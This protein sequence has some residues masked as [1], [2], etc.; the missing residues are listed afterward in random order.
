MENCEFAG[1]L[2]SSCYPL[3][4]SVFYK[5]GFYK[6]PVGPAARFD[7]AMLKKY[8]IED[9]DISSGHYTRHRIQL[10]SVFLEMIQ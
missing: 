9:Q 7:E 5:T 10:L 6:H 2:K 1:K 3:F 8:I 4:S